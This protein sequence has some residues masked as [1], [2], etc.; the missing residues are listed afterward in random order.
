MV[1][2]YN[3]LLTWGKKY[4]QF[5]LKP[6]Y[7]CANYDELRSELSRIQAQ[8]PPIRIG[9][10]GT[11]R[12][13]TGALDILNHLHIQQLN[14]EELKDA[15]PASAVFVNFRNED[16][17][18]RTDDPAAPWDVHHF[19]HHHENYTSQFQPYLNRIDLLINGFYWEPTLPALFAKEDTAKPNFAIK[20]IAD[21][22]CDVEG[23]VPITLRA[24]YP[25][26]PTF[27]WNPATQAEC[28]PYQPN[29]IDV[30]AVTVLPV[31]LPADSSQE[32]GQS[33]LD[34]VIPLLIK[35]DQNEIIQRATITENG[36]LTSNYQYLKDFVKGD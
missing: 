22:T 13:A 20:V 2:A 19:Y 14:P 34:E 4:G 3:G 11:G 27:G 24:T 36:H 18:T 31:E 8:L 26:D 30:M 16:I 33:L 17:Y 35:G 15:Q 29:T 25:H 5:E 7:K 9:L 12:V 1:G 6:A 28:E 32:F 23:S 10:T 21:I